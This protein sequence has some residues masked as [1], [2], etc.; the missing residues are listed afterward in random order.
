MTSTSVISIDDELKYL[1][2]PKVINGD[3]TEST[4]EEQRRKQMRKDFSAAKFETEDSKKYL[5][6]MT[7]D[8]P[9]DNLYSLVD[10]CH[11]NRFCE[12]APVVFKVE[13]QNFIE[14]YC[15]VNNQK[16]DY[17]LQVWTKFGQLY[18]ERKLK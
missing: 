6:Q 2:P 15:T 1:R 10:T 13:C 18:F 7:F 11:S 17:L 12:F 8:V 16:Y 5:K 4:Q 14:A 3:K 9:L